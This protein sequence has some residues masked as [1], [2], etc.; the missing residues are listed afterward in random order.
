MRTHGH[1]LA[2]H[3]LPSLA[4]WCFM[5]AALVS[6]LLTARCMQVVMQNQG[7]SEAC[8][9]DAEYEFHAGHTPHFAISEACMIEAL[10]LAYNSSE[11]EVGRR[12]RSQPGVTVSLAD[13]GDPTCAPIYF[14][15]Y[16]RL[17]A[18]GYSAGD[19][20]DLRWRAAPAPASATTPNTLNKFVGRSMFVACYDWRTV[21]GVDVTPGH[22]F[23][24]AARRLVERAYRSNG[25]RRVFLLGHSNGGPMAQALLAAQSREWRE[26]YVAGLISYAGN[27]A[28]QGSMVAYLFTGWSFVD[29][30]TP[31]PSAAEALQTWPALY[32]S[33][34]QPRVYGSAEDVIRV[35]GGRSYTPADL[36][37]LFQDAGL[38]LAAELFPLFNEITSPETPP[39]VST[40]S[41]YGTG[42]STIVGYE[43]PVLAQG[44][45]VS[46]PILAAGDGDQEDIDNQSNI[47]WAK[48]ECHSFEAIEVPR[49]SHLMLPFEFSVM[50]RT[51][52]ILRAEQGGRPCIRMPVTGVGQQ[53]FQHH[54]VAA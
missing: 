41:F 40:F 35:A 37:D 54:G 42:I 32:F 22:T 12:F 48:M 10:A 28:G 13:F 24:S 38:T 16:L 44:V 9:S 2:A 15:L 30:L 43:L 39:G 19:N 26:Q 14:P 50:A 11:P 5:L 27:W 52:E 8:P 49:A 33:M 7:F 51:V 23:L 31:V 1:L 20:S 34:P 21:P 3:G 53:V 47:G 46:S 6:W 45:R 25:R 17:M 36:Q 18:A 29:F 4:T